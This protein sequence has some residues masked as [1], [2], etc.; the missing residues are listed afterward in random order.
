MPNLISGLRGVYYAK[1]TGRSKSPR[2]QRTRKTAPRSGATLTY[3]NRA[4]PERGALVQVRW[5]RSDFEQ[6]VA[7]AS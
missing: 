6:K 4:L 2:P 1:P 3:E 5:G 7:L